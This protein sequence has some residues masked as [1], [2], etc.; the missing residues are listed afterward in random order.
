MKTGGVEGTWSV[1]PLKLLHFRVFGLGLADGQPCP[2]RG[3]VFLRVGFGARHGLALSLSEQSSRGDYFNPVSPVPK[4][5]AEA[6][7]VATALPTAFQ[8]LITL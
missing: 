3:R 6:T 8:A 7:P 5:Y 4:R 2:P 1:A